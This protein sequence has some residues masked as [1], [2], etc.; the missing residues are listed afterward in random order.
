MK[1]SP[2]DERFMRRALALAR[3]GLGK[4][5][6]NPATGA[7]LVKNGHIIAEDFHEK[8]GQLHAE[9]KVLRRVGAKARGATLYSTLEPCCTWGKTPPCTDAIIAVRVRRVVYAATDPNPKHSGRG[10]KLLR[11]AGIRVDVGLLADEATRM[12]AAFNKWITTGR[13]LVVA[14]AAM[15]VDGK[16]ATRTGDSKWITSEAARREAHKLRALVDA[17]IVGANTVIRDDPRL[18]VRHGTRN[19][20]PWRVVM[21]ARGRSPRKARLFTDKFRHRTIVFTTRLS[22]PQWRRHLALAGATVIVVP[23]TKS[24]ID[25]RTALRELG[26]MEVT[27][28][29]AEGGGGLLGSMFDAGLVDRV[30]LFYAPL[31][32]GG[33]EAVTAVGGQGVAKVAQAVRLHECRWRRIGKSEML[34]EAKVAR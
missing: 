5:S 18:T 2:Q 3:R 1:F 25:V 17:I 10:A 19:W 30:A 11:Q 15:S 7:V 20:Q 13:P 9:A 6:P 26:R 31:V 8:A 29:L 34:L 33:R 22:P 27:S 24:R 4:T 14:K 12:N 23:A 21:D 16:I 32:I 28:V